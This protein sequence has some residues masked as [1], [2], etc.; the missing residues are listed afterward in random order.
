MYYSEQPQQS[1]KFI[2]I[3]QYINQPNLLLLNQSQIKIHDPKKSSYTNQEGTWSLENRQSNTPTRPQISKETYDEPEEVFEPNEFHKIEYRRTKRKRSKNSPQSGNQGGKQRT[4]SGSIQT[5]N[6]FQVL[7]DQTV[8]DK[9]YHTNGTYKTKK[10][11]IQKIP[12]F[13][14]Y[15]VNNKVQNLLELIKS[16]VSHFTYQILSENKRQIQTDRA[17]NYKRLKTLLD[18]NKI[19]RNTYKLPEGKTYKVSTKNISN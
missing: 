1:Y 12:P 3:P 4:N 8:N 9:N 5:K 7:S 11:E 6:S 19:V 2:L 10:T 18:D 15:G 16:A 17:E 14:L 13:I